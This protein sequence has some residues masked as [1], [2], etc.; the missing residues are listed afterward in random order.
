MVFPATGSLLDQRINTGLSP[1][2]RIKV[3]PT[4]VG[5]I[6]NLRINSTREMLVWEEIGTDGIVEIHPRNATKIDVNVERIVFDQLRILEAFNRGYIN[7]QSQ[8]FPFDIQIIDVSSATNEQEATVESIHNCWFNTYSRTYTANN[9]II[10][11]AATLKA[12]KIT[13]MKNSINVAQG[14]LRG[15]RFEFDSL[16]RSIDLEGRI[17]RIDSSSNQTR[18][19]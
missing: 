17:G 4:T 15:L 10:T 9:F 8:R 13:A 5:A 16:E 2:I 1:Q 7:L 6:Q 14:G 18:N 3:G 11:E 19:I 12:E